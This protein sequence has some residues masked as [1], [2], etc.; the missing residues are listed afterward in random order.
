MKYIYILALLTL[1]SCASNKRKEQSVIMSES[2]NVDKK[3]NFSTLDS[4]NI[5]TIRIFT[6]LEKE[7]IDSIIVTPEKVIY[8]GVKKNNEIQDSTYTD[9][10][11]IKQTEIESTEAVES[12]V[13][14]SE[15]KTKDKFFYNVGIFIFSLIIIFFIIKRVK[16]F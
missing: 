7:N 2:R 8:Y 12:S 14:L 6:Q 3:E 16:L 1:V 9:F 5:N 11:D 4:V 10:T 15:T 13:L